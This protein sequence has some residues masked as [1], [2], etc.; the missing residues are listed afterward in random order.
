MTDE[1]KKKKFPSIATSG[2]GGGFNAMISTS[3]KEN[4]QASPPALTTIIP[5]PDSRKNESFSVRIQDSERIKDYAHMMRIQTKNSLYTN[6]EALD[7]ILDIAFK[8]IGEIPERPEE[9]KNAEK[10]GRPRNKR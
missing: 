5:H 2:I 7:A 8:Q 9:V 1:S 10:R 3:D 4:K 6:R